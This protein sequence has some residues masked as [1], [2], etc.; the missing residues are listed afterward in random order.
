MLRY[1][2]GVASALLLVAAS[3]FIWKSQAESDRPVPPAPQ[4]ESGEAEAGGV[5]APPEASAKTR[6]EKR[7]GRADKDKD[8]RIA[9]EEL[10]QPRRKAFAKLDTNSD[11]RLGFEEWAVSTT[12]KFTGADADRS[13]WLSPREFE[14]TKP[15]TKAKPKR[16]AC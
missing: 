10:Y 4:A 11:G 5:S 7:F 13:G 16:C 8:G 3:F 1:V 6:E 2:A 9:L 15:K 12:E 14:T